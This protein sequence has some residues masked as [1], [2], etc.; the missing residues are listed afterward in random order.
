MDRLISRYLPDLHLSWPKRY[1][2]ATVIIAVAVLARWLLGDH[3]AGYPLLLFWPAVVLV[4]LLLDSGT[5]YYA[6]AVSVVAA[7]WFADPA[8]GFVPH[9]VQDTVALVFFAGVCGGLVLV[10]EELRKALRHV[11][12]AEREKGLLLREIYHRIAND[13]QRMTGM[14]TLA[15]YRVPPEARQEFAKA[16]ER[17]HVLGWVYASLKRTEGH[18]VLALKPFLEDMTHALGR[19]YGHAQ[20][21]VLESDIGDAEVS[22][23]RASGIGL[24]VNELVTNAYKYAFPDGRP[25]RIIVRFRKRFGCKV[26]IV[27]DDGAGL[28]DAP[29]MGLGTTLVRELVDQMGGCMKTISVRGVRVVVCLPIEA[30]KPSRRRTAK[31]P[32]AASV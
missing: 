23:S 28:S 25:G 10:T 24:I 17:L 7:C 18:A 31:A 19:T 1:G 9:K 3:L 4:A 16:A 20:S 13:L 15:S 11:A 32:V 26:L 30:R 2:F 6:T 8:D 29:G 27:Q 12:S 5:G 21:I 14:L 22:L